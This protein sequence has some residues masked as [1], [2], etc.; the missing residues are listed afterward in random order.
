MS[1][2]AIV[3][4]SFGTRLVHAGLA[5][6]VVLQL[7]TSL[8]MQ[9]PRPGRPANFAFDLH[10]IFGV[11]AL[12]CALGFWVVIVTRI[13][14]T[15]AGR[16]V[17]WFSG[18][19]LAAL[20]ADI[21]AHWAAAR[22]LRLPDYDPEG[23]L[24]SAVHGLGLLLMTYMA[25]SGT[26]Y[27]IAPR[28][29]YEESPLLHSAMDLHAAFGNLVWAYLIGHAGLAAIHHFTSGL[30]IGEMWSLRRAAP[31]SLRNETQG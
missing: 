30:R 21:V 2:T 14:G 5:S 13:A 29:G 8:V 26:M 4:H 28:I 6:A 12:V 3:R 27:L 20:R 17:P 10:Q 31:V 22:R 24:A 15:D 16:L 23:A 1:Q 25:I 18:T 19:R 11:A 9:V 7:A